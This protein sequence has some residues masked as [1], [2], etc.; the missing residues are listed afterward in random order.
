MFVLPTSLPFTLKKRHLR[1]QIQLLFISVFCLLNIR[2]CRFHL[3]KSWLTEPGGGVLVQRNAVER[4]G[5]GLGQLSDHDGGHAKDKAHAHD[6]E[7]KGRGSQSLKKNK[8]FYYV[9]YIE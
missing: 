9:N 7:P 8:K 4:R 3:I 5:V 1:I 2:K 6:D